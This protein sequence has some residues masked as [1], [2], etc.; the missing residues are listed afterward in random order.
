MIAGSSSGAIQRRLKLRLVCDHVEV[1]LG[2]ALAIPG[3]CFLL[4]AIVSGGVAW[5]ASYWQAFPPPNPIGKATPDPLVSLLTWAGPVNVLLVTAPPMIAAGIWLAAR[6]AFRPLIFR[7]TPAQTLI[8]AA[9]WDKIAPPDPLS[10]LDAAEQKRQAALARSARWTPVL[11]LIA[12]VQFVLYLIILGFR[13][14]LVFLEP[15]GEQSVMERQRLQNDIEAVR[16]A[17]R[18]G[19]AGEAT[20]RLFPNEHQ[21]FL[22]RKQA[23]DEP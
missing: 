20:N 7:M 4:L 2:R 18:E 19:K 5:L 11:K 14:T 8:S 9:D 1:S 15:A 16:Q 3:L 21:E 6:A 23:E 13:L 22:Q 10:D 12:C 17:V